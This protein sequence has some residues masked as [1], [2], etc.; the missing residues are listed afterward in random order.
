MGMLVYFWVF[1]KKLFLFLFKKQK[2]EQFSMRRVAVWR[3]F[4]MWK[5]VFICFYIQPLGGINNW[6]PIIVPTIMRSSH[7][8]PKR[9]LNQI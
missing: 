1:L 2:Q 9:L 7:V 6:K 5:F 3:N 8:K 4:E